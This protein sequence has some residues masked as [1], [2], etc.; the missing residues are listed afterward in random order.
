MMTPLTPTTAP[1]T[2]PSTPAFVNMI[3]LFLSTP[4]KETLEQ[5]AAPTPATPT[6]PATPAQIADAMIRSMLGGT[7][8]NSALPVSSSPAQTVPA[9]SNQAAPTAPS[10][11]APAP[12]Q[13]LMDQL[14]PAPVAA[15]SVPGAKTAIEAPA[16]KKRAADP[17]NIPTA[18]DATLV[19]PTPVPA[20]PLSPAPSK[21]NE[22]AQNPIAQLGASVSVI[23]AKAQPGGKV[24]F[25]A[26][27]TP[28]K[29]A[30]PANSPAEPAKQT[31]AASEPVESAAPIDP[32]ASADPQSGAPVSKS[33]LS[34][35][36]QIAEPPAEAEKTGDTPSQQQD[37]S[38]QAA[39]N[40]IVEPKNK[41][42]AAKQDESDPQ[43]AVATISAA[44]N[45]PVVTAAADQPRFA[46][47]TQAPAQTEPPSRTMAEAL[48]TSESELPAAPPARTGAAQEI[49]IRIEQPDSSPVDLR[50][51]ERSGQ[52]H[53]DV[54]TPDA[55]MQT[56]LRQDL[57]T[58]TNSLQ[59]AGF[60]AD[61]FTPSTLGR[62][63]SSAQTS[64]QDDQ[65][66]PSQNRGGSADH[67]E[68]RRQQPQKRS[69]NWLEEL[70]DQP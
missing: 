53:V 7:T 5:V 50:V 34:T 36:T 32:P 60:H 44:Q 26:I 6:V 24:A 49:A 55:A 9:T 30:Q 57:G 65:R 28:E 14:S 68:G 67:S 45:L 17:N 42:A 48:R 46:P 21:S 66:D 64:N 31:L 29:E 41:A 69:S 16:P 23:P 3:S 70:E 2:A 47:E 20:T 56:A 62:T 27:L 18:T 43:T 51:V 11:A 39:P 8:S 15:G 35:A 38:D 59:R 19:A 54:R 12:A 25:T 61:V 10:Q 58:L 63:A 4:N 1:H 22:P 40:I 33:A 37:S 13:L 52:L